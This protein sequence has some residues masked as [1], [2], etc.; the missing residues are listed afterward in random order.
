M[1]STCAVYFFRVHSVLIKI[2]YYYKVCKLQCNIRYTSSSAILSLLLSMSCSFCTV[3]LKKQT[4]TIKCLSLLQQAVLS[5]HHLHQSLI[6]RSWEYWHN[7]HVPSW[8]NTLPI[9]P[10]I[11]YSKACL[12]H[13][14]EPSFQSVY[15]LISS[16]NICL[17][18]WKCF[19]CFLQ[20]SLTLL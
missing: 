6:Y 18:L 1:A 8:H 13:K 15:S 4:G 12:G 20:L 9:S 2:I 14:N 5:W 19:L 11:Y 10:P 3:S 16:S 17:L 7:H